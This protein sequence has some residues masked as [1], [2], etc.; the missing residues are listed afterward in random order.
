ML[1]QEQGTILDRIDYNIENALENTQVA[2]K[3]LVKA[4]NYMK[5]NCFRNVIMVLLFWC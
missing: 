2:H 4:N 5:K 3:E 1:V